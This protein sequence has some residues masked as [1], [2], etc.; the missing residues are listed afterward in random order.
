MTMRNKYEKEQDFKGE[1]TSVHLLIAE[2]LKK[3]YYSNL[4]QFLIPDLFAI[5]FWFGKKS[6]DNIPSDTNAKSFIKPPPDM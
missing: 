3:F 1:S 2:V 4:P 6:C 5:T